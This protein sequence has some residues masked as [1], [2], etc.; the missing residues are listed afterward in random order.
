MAD[1]F[2]FGEYF[3]V[4]AELLVLL[5]FGCWYFENIL[6]TNLFPFLLGQIKIAKF[7]Y[8]NSILLVS[9]IQSDDWPIFTFYFIRFSFFSRGIC[10]WCARNFTFTVEKLEIV[11]PLPKRNDCNSL[12]FCFF[13]LFKLVKM[14]SEATSVQRMKSKIHFGRSR[15]FFSYVQD[16]FIKSINLCRILK[17]GKNIYIVRG[18][19]AK[20]KHALK[21]AIY[22]Q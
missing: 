14:L 20:A 3:L 10:S 7:K 9:I 16:Y 12:F 4:C 8:Q 6:H 18:A 19:Y 15:V 5:D 17:T 21:S 22:L 11:F 2:F 13:S 1:V